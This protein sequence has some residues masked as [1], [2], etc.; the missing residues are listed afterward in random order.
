MDN[1]KIRIHCFE[2][3]GLEGF[4]SNTYETD[5]INSAMDCIKDL[6]TNERSGISRILIENPKFG[7]SRCYNYTNAQSPMEI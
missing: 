1:N 2:T 5:N 3:L 6:L 7:D 4:P